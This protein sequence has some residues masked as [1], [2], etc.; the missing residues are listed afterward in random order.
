MHP[1]RGSL[2]GTVVPLGEADRAIG[3]TRFSPPSMPEDDEFGGP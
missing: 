3:R 2:A 1:L